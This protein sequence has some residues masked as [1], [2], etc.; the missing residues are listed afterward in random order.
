MHKH[1]VEEIV[2]SEETPPKPRV[3]LC[4]CLLVAK[5]PREAERREGVSPVYVSN[6]CPEATEQRSTYL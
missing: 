2:T 4:D 6:Y 1:L 3:C 5:Q